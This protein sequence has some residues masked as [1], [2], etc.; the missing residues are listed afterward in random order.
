MTSI[1]VVLL[2]RRAFRVDGF[3]SDCLKEVVFVVE[4][5]RDLGVMLLALRT[6]LSANSKGGTVTGDLLDPSC[7]T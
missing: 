4:R 3:V 5:L 1:D 6:M 7:E 2:F